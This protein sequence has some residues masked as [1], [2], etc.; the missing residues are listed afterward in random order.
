MEFRKIKD[1]P[2]SISLIVIL[3]NTYIIMQFKILSKQKMLPV[4]PPEKPILLYRVQENFYTR[5]T[6][7]LL[8]CFV[9]K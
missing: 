2:L 1:K 6:H 9:F 8:R 3:F 4:L 7:I 5:L